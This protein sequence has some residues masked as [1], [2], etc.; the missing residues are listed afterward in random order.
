MSD[1]F[2]QKFVVNRGV[3]TPNLKMCMYKKLFL[4]VDERKLTT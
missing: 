2:F 4:C 3:G 1:F